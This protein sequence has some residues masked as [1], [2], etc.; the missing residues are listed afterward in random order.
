MNSFVN[1]LKKNLRTL[2]PWAKRFPCDAY[3]IYDRDIPEYAVSVDFYNGKFAVY[4]YFNKLFQERDDLHF[5]DVMEGIQSVFAVKPSDI[6]IKERARQKGL[7]QYEKVGNHSVTHLVTEGPAR[8][9]VN[10]SDYLDTGLFLDHR[11]SRKWVRSNSSQKRVL[12]LFCYTG[13]V[14]VH[15]IYGGARQVVSVD[16]SSTYLDWAAANLELNGFVEHQHPLVRANV[17]DWIGNLPSSEKFDLIFLD[18][19]SFSN[20]KKMKEEFDVQRDHEWLVERCMEHVSDQGTL[21]FSNNLRS[22]RLSTEL[23]SRH[24]VS[25]ITRKTLPPDF[26]NEL[27]HHAWLMQHRRGVP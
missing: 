5:K 11:E 14:S 7:A 1:R 2:E 20:S 13:S 16:M 25:E 4:R 10:M 18:P 19:P 22:F 23:Q 9:I 3:R 17:I 21:F 12:N 15:A 6:F 26:R 24:E 8:F 27:I